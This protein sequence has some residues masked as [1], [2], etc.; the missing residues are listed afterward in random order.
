V[1]D[2]EP[3]HVRG[4]CDLA[5]CEGVASLAYHDEEAGI[6]VEVCAE[7][8]SSLGGFD[9]DYERV[10]HDSPHR[11]PERVETHACGGDLRVY[12]VNAGDGDSEGDDDGDENKNKNKN[13]NEDIDGA[14]TEAVHRVC[15]GVRLRGS[16]TAH[17]GEDSM[18]VKTASANPDTV[19]DTS[20]DEGR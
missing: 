18:T 7:H 2:S 13:K 6:Y 11:E 10:E 17:T 5:D 20:S 9:S 4:L 8:A 16:D 19:S 15:G 1:T 12:K 3:K 14:E